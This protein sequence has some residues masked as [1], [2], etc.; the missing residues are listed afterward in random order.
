[1]VN[2]GAGYARVARRASPW[3]FVAFTGVL[4]GCR[5]NPPPP[6]G[7]TVARE[8]RERI[9]L[10]PARSDP[11]RQSTPDAPRGALSE[12]DAVNL[13]LEQNAAFREQLAELGL[14]RADVIQA[15]LI[16]NPDLLYLFP[17]GAKQAESTLTIPLEFLWLR[18]GRVAV[19]RDT[20]D[21]TSARLVQAGMDLVRD[22][23]LGYADL[24]LARRR[25]ALF[26]EAARL[27][28]R[29]A[30][31]AAARV[32]AGDA[33]P[34]DEVTA[35][36]DALRAREEAVRLEY[37][38]AIAEERLRALLGL[39]AFR[40]PLEL[41][42]NA[43]TGVDADA[44]VGS[45]DAVDAL[46]ERAVADRPDARSADLAV[47]AASKRARVARAELFTLSAAA[48][49]NQR[50]SSGAELGPGV[51]LG[52]PVFNQN[53]GV[54]ARADAELERARRQRQ[55]LRDRIILE[56]REAHARVAQARRDRDAWRTQVLPALEQA[57]GLAEKAYQGGETPLLLVLDASRQLLDAR[58]REAQVDSD[59]RRARAE[60]ERAVGR[61]LD[62]LSP[63]DLMPS[64]GGD[65]SL[66][67]APEQMR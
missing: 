54:V 48:D 15:G 26:R 32:R 22:A 13:A 9:G 35:R 4:G 45:P 28:T 21:R 61:R 49:Y 11:R 51:R 3:V 58:V 30:D 17:L 59:L 65:E 64:R 41:A 12:N 44:T 43:G 8:V 39:G 18:G 36:V 53:Q 20:A 40:S 24:A 29:V 66:P 23:R 10:A 5:G 63:S 46:V 37:D 56:V 27:R 60:L 38:A 50:G 16:P 47:A 2:A 55:T 33:L 42:V 6:G 1:M 67:A 7:A 25:L 34:L 31:L 19:A 57:V 14:T 52:V 62:V